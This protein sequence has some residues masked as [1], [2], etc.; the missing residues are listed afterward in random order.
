MVK[1]ITAALE[2]LLSLLLLLVPNVD[3]YLRDNIRAA[4]QSFKRYIDKCYN[5]DF[6][7]FWIYK[8]AAIFYPSRFCALSAD[9]WTSTVEF[10]KEMCTDQEILSPFEIHERYQTEA[11]VIHGHAVRRR[12]STS[13]HRGETGACQHFKYLRA[14]F[15]GRVSNN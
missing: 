7:G 10:V 13:T 6:T 8:V 11:R 3:A 14:V 1:I 12:L 15:Q 2:H 5:E 9:K 4:H